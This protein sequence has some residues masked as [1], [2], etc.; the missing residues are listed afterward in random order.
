MS[1]HV[2]YSRKNYKLTPTNFTYQGYTEP[3]KNIADLYVVEN[4]KKQKI[5]AGLTL[6]IWGFFFSFIPGSIITVL[7]GAFIESENRNDAFEH[8]QILGSIILMSIFFILGYSLR[9]KYRLFIVKSNGSK[10]P[11]DKNRKSRAEFDEL[12]FTVKK[13]IAE[14]C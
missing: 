1:N 5:I 2:I 12:I 9:A 14:Y 6:S 4:G 13:A 3:L 8:T 7:I 11:I 10:G